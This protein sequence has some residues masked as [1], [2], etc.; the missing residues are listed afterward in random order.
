[1]PPRLSELAVLL[2]ALLAGLA[3]TAFEL[4]WVRLAIPLLGNG[5]YA[6]GAGAAAYLVG[7]GLGGHLAGRRADGIRHPGRAPACLALL[8][9]APSAQVTTTPMVESLA[10]TRPV[11]RNSLKRRLRPPSKR[12]TATE[13]FTR[14]SRTSPKRASGSRTP[15]TG[16]ARSP[17]ASNRRIDGRRA[18]QASHCAE[19]PSARTVAR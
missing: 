11:W 15:K 12:M 4:A 17:M 9:A 8:A 7:L 14:G 18:R 5:A 6:V 13:S 19:M 16:P 3:S 1:M 2:A 10:T